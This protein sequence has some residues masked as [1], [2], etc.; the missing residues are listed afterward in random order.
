MNINPFNLGPSKT[1]DLPADFKDPFLRD[2]IEVISMSIRRGCLNRTRVY[3]SGYV[4]FIQGNTAGQQK[5]E[6]ETFEE[7][8]VKMKAFLESI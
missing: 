4:D 5:F 3:V 1:A 6:A 2:N 7:L 8:L